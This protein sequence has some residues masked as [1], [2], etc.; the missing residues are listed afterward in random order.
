LDDLGIVAAIAWQAQEFQTRTGIRCKT[1]S[2]VEEIALHCSRSTAFFRIFQEVLTN[3]ARYANATSVYV[4]LKDEAGNPMLEV[5][6]EGKGI[7]E[8]DISNL[9]R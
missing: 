2:L 9:K 5:Q 7:A 4:S 1:I 8:S 3:V 6:D